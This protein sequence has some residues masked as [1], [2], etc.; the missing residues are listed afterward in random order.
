MSAVVVDRVSLR[1]HR[2]MQLRR[3]YLSFL[4]E[5]MYLHVES[6]EIQA[7]KEGLAS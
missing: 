6:E 7:Q 3:I 5:C 4:I 2:E 1:L